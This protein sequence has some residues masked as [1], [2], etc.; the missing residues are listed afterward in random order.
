MSHP[1]PL[2]QGTVMEGRITWCYIDPINLINCILLVLLPYYWFTARKMQD[3]W[4][5]Q[6][7]LKN[8]E[9]V[10][11]ISYGT[12]DTFHSLF[13]LQFCLRN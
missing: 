10:L 7:F 3:R 12:I 13:I 4:F 8:F 2:T 5:T 11:E 1:L 6:T 9:Y